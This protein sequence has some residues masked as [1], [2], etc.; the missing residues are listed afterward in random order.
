FSSF[1]ATSGAPGQ[2][3]YAA[4]NAFLDALALHR[5]AQGLPAVSLAWGWWADTSS[6]TGRLGQSDHAR[7]GRAG[8]RAMSAAEGLALFDL[9]CRRPEANLVPIRLELPR[10]GGSE[11]VPPLL[12]G[13]VARGPARPVASAGDQDGSG[14]AG[15]L[16]GLTAADQ[17]RL[18][19]DLVC[20]HVATVLGHASGV[21]V[22]PEKALRDMGFDSL[23][24]VELRNRLAAVTGLQ[25]P[26]TLA[27]DHPTVSRMAGYLHTR[28]APTVD[29][30]SSE[31]RL[32]E[33]LASIPFTRLRDAG[34]MDVL[35]R[36]AGA[37][38]D[39]PPSTEKQLDEMDA[40]ALIDFV[41][42]ER[43]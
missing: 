10:H 28:L 38:E 37:S 22:D 15:R 7:L 11:P 41:L 34:L 3:N 20:G 8:V 9:A 33:A 36:L 25:L 4:A 19:L 35:L 23:T 27:F 13:L 16:V 31:A 24:T 42:D 26:A 1:A 39:A 6:M 40:E 29:T 2:G 12:R 5:H 18:L 43:N 21:A 17:Q 30:D 32:R 14:L